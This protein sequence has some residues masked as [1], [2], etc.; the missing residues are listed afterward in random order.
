MQLKTAAAATGGS[1]AA[2]IKDKIDREDAKVFAGFV[3]NLI[4]GKDIDQSLQALASKTKVVASQKNGTYTIQVPSKID[5][6][7]GKT[8]KFPPYIIN[9]QTMSKA[10]AARALTTAFNGVQGKFVEPYIYEYLNKSG[11]VISEDLN[12]S[13]MPNPFFPQPQTAP[14]PITTS[15]YNPIV[16]PPIKK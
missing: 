6:F 16:T 12:N 4:A 9:T 5:N 1:N 10:D 11:Q 2:A 13:N 8:E 14:S 15:Q 7:T 3:E